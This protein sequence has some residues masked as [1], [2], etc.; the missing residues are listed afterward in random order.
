MFTT[1]P[2]AGMISVMFIFP[3]G[4]GDSALQPGQDPV[5]EMFAKADWFFEH[6]QAEAA[7]DLCE[8]GIAM[9]PSRAGGYWRQANFALTTRRRSNGLSSLDVLARVKPD[10][11]SDL[12]YRTLRDRLLQLPADQLER[13]PARELVALETLSRMAAQVGDNHQSLV[14][15]LMGART[16]PNDV[17]ALETVVRAASTCGMDSLAK[18]A[19]DGLPR[20]EPSH[21]QSPRLDPLARSTEDPTIADSRRGVSTTAALLRADALLE[22]LSARSAQLELKATSLAVRSI[23]ETHIADPECDD[24]RVWRRVAAVSI[25]LE[26]GRLAAYAATKINGEGSSEVADTQKQLLRL[27]RPEDIDAARRDRGPLAA[28]RRRGEA[29]EVDAWPKLANAYG[30]GEGAPF[31]PDE[32]ARWT[33]LAVCSGVEYGVGAP[34]LFKTNALGMKLAYVPPGEFLMGSP[35]DEH[36]RL[37]GES[38]HRVLI[39][40]GFWIGTTEVRQQQYEMLMGTRGSVTEGDR[41]PSDAVSWAEAVEFCKRLSIVA[42]AKY[43]L[44]TEAQWEFACRA[45][46][47]TPFGFG[48]E[49]TGK[50]ATVAADAGP[51]KL[52]PTGS[53]PANRWGLRD[54]HGNV[55]EWCLDGYRRY[56][57]GSAIDPFGSPQEDLHVLRGG[58]FRDPP[59]RC[60]SAERLQIRASFA[61]GFGFRVVQLVQ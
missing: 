45:G 33:D 41:L 2:L 27:A 9:D 37:A 1:L 55:A 51:Q 18:L 7:A 13:S 53:F 42:C 59:E 31:C 24:P 61:N 57:G 44:P 16:Q 54:M 3:P 30:T 32:A 43:T 22:S 35:D 52:S 21:T 46:T 26:D 47:T 60:R 15:A 17:I 19:R 40:R 25:A 34:V 4:G 39:T 48:G 10:A 38:S 58:S 8:V 23:L 49:L 11:A 12:D 28:L 20:S 6:G 14:W 56:E 5:V 50:Q 29:G 36:G